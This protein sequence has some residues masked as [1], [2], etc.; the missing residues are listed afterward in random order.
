[1]QKWVSDVFEA[2]PVTEHKDD[3][4][5]QPFLVN[6]GRYCVASL[7]SFEKTFDHA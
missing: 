4:E 1:M 3:I 6:M 5:R 2:S 7:A